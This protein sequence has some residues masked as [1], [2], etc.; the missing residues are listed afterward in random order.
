MVRQF[1]W[2]PA[3][4][5]LGCMNLPAI[6]SASLDFGSKDAALAKAK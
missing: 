2:A 6:G 4:R 1:N 5:H 3:S